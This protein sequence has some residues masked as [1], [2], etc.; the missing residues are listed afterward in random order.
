MDSK[1]TEQVVVFA[2]DN[3]G[4]GIQEM[5]PSELEC[6]RTD[7]AASSHHASMSTVLEA[8][9]AYTSH[10]YL[11]DIMQLCNMCWWLGITTLSIWKINA[12]QRQAL[13]CF[14]SGVSPYFSRN[15]TPMLCCCRQTGL[16]SCTR[17]LRRRSASCN[18]GHHSAGSAS[19]KLR[20][21]YHWCPVFHWYTHQCNRKMGRRIA[22]VSLKGKKNLWC[23]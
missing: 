9:A 21:V 8:L 2:L 20:H 17:G 12:Q 10:I 15:C 13:Q 14:L 1:S 19:Q 7:F 4:C 18:L 5:N 16:P 22:L 3:L 6:N 23:H 11:L